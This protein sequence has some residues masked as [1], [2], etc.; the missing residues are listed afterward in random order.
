MKSFDQIRIHFEPSVDTYHGISSILNVEP[1][2]ERPNKLGDGTPSSWTYEVVEDH[3]TAYYDFIN[4]FLNLLE[5]K[6]EEL[7]KLGIERGDITFWYLYEYDGQCN[8]E[9]DSKS[10]KR[11]GDNEISLCISCWNSGKE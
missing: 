9:F 11:L 4:Q 7:Q 1:K 10:L 2:L 8:M 6:F 5:G 3:D